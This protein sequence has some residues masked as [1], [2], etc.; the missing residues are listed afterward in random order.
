MSNSTVQRTVA[1]SAQLLYLKTR[2]ERNRP[3]WRLLDLLGIALLNIEVL[4][5]WSCWRY[6]VDCLYTLCM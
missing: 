6:A 5:K 2:T 4:N 1:L 3:W